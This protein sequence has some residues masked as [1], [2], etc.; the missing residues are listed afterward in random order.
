MFDFSPIQIIIVLAIVLLVFG[1]KRLPE[2]GRSLGHG[3][4]DFKRSMS[5]EE[6]PEPTSTA[7]MTTAEAQTPP[8]ELTTAAESD[9]AAGEPVGMAAGA[10]ST[11]REP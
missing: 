10:E 2:L 4:R 9:D 6:A 1:P 7:T 11:S 8:A 5:G 3:L